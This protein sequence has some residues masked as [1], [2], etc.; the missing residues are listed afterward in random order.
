MYKQSELSERILN[1]PED[2]TVV[3]VIID[4][5]S[6]DMAKEYFP[7]E[8]IIVDGPSNTADGMMRIVGIP[9]IAQK[10]YN[11]GTR[12]L[13]G[14]SY[15][16]RDEG[17]ELSSKMFAPIPEKN[18][19]V[20][21]SFDQVLNDLKTRQTSRSLHSDLYDGFR[22][23]LPRLSRYATNQTNSTPNKRKT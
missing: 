3:F 12:N 4:G 9:T 6:F 7:C 22:W 16:S 23:V 1:T 5:L 18:M 10:M 17:N 19:V 21:A 15:W 8:P 11:R 20:Y 13:I 14:Y 2:E